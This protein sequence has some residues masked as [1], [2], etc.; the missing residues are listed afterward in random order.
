MKKFSKFLKRTIIGVLPAVFACSLSIGSL[1]DA[2]PSFNVAH[3]EE[4]LNAPV[5]DYEDEF[6][7]ARKTGD[8]DIQILVNAE[9]GKYRNIHLD[10]LRNFFDNIKNMVEDIARQ[11][12]KDLSKNPIQYEPDPVK[13][14]GG[15]EGQKEEHQEVPIGIEVPP[16]V[17]ESNKYGSLETFENFLVEYVN[18]DPVEDPKIEKIQSYNTV[19]YTYFYLDQFFNNN[20]EIE[21]NATNYGYAYRDM[22]ALLGMHL[23]SEFGLSEGITYQYFYNLSIGVTAPEFEICLDDVTGMLLMVQQKES[24]AEQASNVTGIRDMIDSLGGDYVKEQIRALVLTSEPLEVATFFAA[25]EGTINVVQYTLRYVHFGLDD[26]TTLISENSVSKWID[27]VDALGTETVRQVV[28]S[29]EGFETNKFINEV[30]KHTSPKDIWKSLKDIRIDGIKIMEDK[31]FLF[32]GIKELIKTFPGFRTAS[33]LKDNQFRRKFAIRMNSAMDEIELNAEI[34]FKGNCNL[35]RRVCKFIADHFHYQKID[36]VH[37]I[38]VDAPIA[39]ENFYKYILN[40]EGFDDE[41]RHEIFDHLFGTIEDAYNWA[42]SKTIEDLKANADQIHYKELFETIIDADEINKMFGIDYWTPEKVKSFVDDLLSLARKVSGV[43]L[44]SCIEFVKRY[45]SFSE[46]T[47][48]KIRNYGQRLLNILKR[49]ADGRSFDTF[50]DYLLRHTDEEVQERVMEKIDQYL[51][52]GSRYYSKLLR[53]MEKVFDKIPVSKR[54][55]GIMTYY[56]G[57]GVWNGS[58]NLPVRKLRK[59]LKAIPKIGTKLDSAFG[60]LFEQLPERIKLSVTG[61][62]KNVHGVNWAVEG[63]IVKRAALAETNDIE[64][65]GNMPRVEIEG[66]EKD[67]IGWA[68]VTSDGAA[69]VREMPNRDITV[70]PIVMYESNG[71]S[72]QYDGVE[73]EISVSFNFETGYP[74]TFQWYKD[75]VEVAGATSKTLSVKNVADS[76]KY[77]C[78]VNGISSGE[79]NVT[80]TK[81]GVTAPTQTE[82]LY[83]NGENHSYYEAFGATSEEGL[84][85]YA[86]GSDAQQNEVGNWQTVLS[87]VDEDN[88]EWTGS[89][90]FTWSI[91]KGQIPVSS[92][93]IQ[94]NYTSPLEYT[95]EPQTIYLDGSLLPEGV[96]AV[97]NEDN[98]KTEIGTYTASVTIVVDDPDHYVIIGQTVY[99]QTWQIK[100]AIIEIPAEVGLVQDTFTYCG[101][102]YKPELDT[103][104]LPEEITG[105]RLSGDTA[106]TEIGN[107]TVEVTYSYDTTHY[108]LKDG[109]QKT[110]EWKIVPGIIDLSNLHW[111]YTEPFKYD[112]QP[113]TVQ[114]VG[115]PNNVK[116]EYSGTVKAVASGRYTAKAKLTC[117]PN[118]VMYYQGEY[119]TELEFDELQWEISSVPPIPT[120]TDFDSEEATEKGQPFVHVHLSKGIAGNLTLHAEQIDNSKY[121][122]NSLVKSGPAEVICA[123]DIYFLDENQNIVNVNVNDNGEIIDKNFTITVTFY[124]ADGIETQ[125]LLVGHAKDDGSVDKMENVIAEKNCVKFNSNHLSVYGVIN[126][127]VSASNKTPLIVVGVLVLV[128]LQ[129]STIFTA[130]ILSKRRRF[131]VHDVK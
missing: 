19:G 113:H 3:A 65:W 44:D 1:K 81:R 91:Q 87:L 72:K 14:T 20:P 36:G 78:V 71:V 120:R 57:E 37:C 101:R 119:F 122:W 104:Y 67:V 47:E 55:V 23:A 10:N 15:E 82:T 102:E 103:T 39:I 9:I 8:H 24:A 61:N 63:N 27:I 85:F 110:F 107:Y 2:K 70:Q 18:T 35:V 126:P 41:L 5:F 73:S 106:K 30:V 48:K 112:G 92:A 128:A 108:I 46:S 76:G 34:G 7:T 123:Y 80:I 127:I 111:D 42:H 50:Q 77:T 125:N 59:V 99:T 114:L 4:A 88:T 74:F 116:V 68:E 45:I 38:T 117:H 62:A 89:N 94:W 31:K 60:A 52:R 49:F 129:A 13:G 56:K 17:F 100:K 121:N 97:Y 32:S 130:I 131:R 105:Y 22:C 53:A 51:D 54:Q 83:Y 33:T 79:I 115:I 95:G 28:Q 96:H 29:V 26:L 86:A 6:F 98:P 12:L 84:E 25:F 66:E 75:G 90:E 118:F 93:N 21:R 16:L 109:Y 11:K 64:F 43:N 69:Y 58:G 124:L 40:A